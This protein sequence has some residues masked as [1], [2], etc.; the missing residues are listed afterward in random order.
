[1]KGFALISHLEEFSAQ[2]LCLHAEDPGRCSNASPLTHLILKCVRGT[3]F[4]QIWESGHVCS[5]HLELS[6]RWVHPL[7]IP[8]PFCWSSTP[9]VAWSETCQTAL[10]AELPLG[11]GSGQDVCPPR[12]TLWPK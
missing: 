9:L 6:S 11:A 10:S 4:L 12:K 1:M 5:L 8:N 3:L 2:G 7:Y